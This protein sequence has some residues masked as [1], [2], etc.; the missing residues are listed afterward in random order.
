[1]TIFLRHWAFTPLTQLSI[2]EIWHTFPFLR[3]IEHFERSLN[4]HACIWGPC[5]P[6]K[7]IMWFM[8]YSPRFGAGLDH[9]LANLEIGIKTCLDPAKADGSLIK[10]FL[11]CWLFMLPSLW[12]YV[13][14]CMH[15]SHWRSCKREISQTLLH[16]LVPK[17]TSE[18][19]Y[20]CTNVFSLTDKLIFPRGDGRFLSHKYNSNLNT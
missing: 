3:I 19:I 10:L 16:P 14:I 17:S 1:M 6:C 4:R 2:P 15:V 20:L 7:T 13:G 11:L 18:R 8:D 9:N 5:G 12:L